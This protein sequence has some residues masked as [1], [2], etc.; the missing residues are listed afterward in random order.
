MN[1]FLKHILPF[2]IV[3]Q[4]NCNQHSVSTSTGEIRVINNKELSEIITGERLNLVFGW[5]TWCNSCQEAFS[6]MEQLDEQYRNSDNPPLITVV[7]FDEIKPEKE[8]HIPSWMK[9][10][11]Y[12][13]GVDPDFLM[14]VYPEK[15][16]G[17]I[18]FLAVSIGK[19]DPAPGNMRMKYFYGM[20]EIKNAHRYIDFINYEMKE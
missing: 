14:S 1:R 20:N 11:L 3:F 8:I 17:S 19:N 2:L 12:I 6:I 9:N 13:S 5:A 15:W 4:L 7:V 10:K 18:P 16:N